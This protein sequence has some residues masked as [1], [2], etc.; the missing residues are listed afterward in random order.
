MSLV[1]C[2]T[3]SMEVRPGFM[4]ACLLSQQILAVSAALP[5]LATWGLAVSSCLAA[6]LAIITLLSCSSPQLGA[7]HARE[8]GPTLAL[9]LIKEAGCIRLQIK[10]STNLCSHLAAGLMVK[11]RVLS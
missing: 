7:H 9:P 3:G 10:G 4:H 6:S 8:K 5:C 2:C 1:T 11:E